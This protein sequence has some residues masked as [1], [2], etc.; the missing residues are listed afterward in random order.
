MKLLA[1]PDSNAIKYEAFHVFKC[2]ASD[3]EKNFVSK[4]RPPV[5]GRVRY[6]QSARKD[7]GNFNF[8]LVRNRYSWSVQG[9]E[10]RK[11]LERK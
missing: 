6:Q 8:S 10:S 4:M 11:S 9:T 5:H 2:F 3:Y 1:H 7:L